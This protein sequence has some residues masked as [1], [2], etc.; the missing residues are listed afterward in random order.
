MY[1]CM[2][3]KVLQKII[4]NWGETQRAPHKINNTALCALT[5]QVITFTRNC[6]RVKIVIIFSLRSI[7]I[8]TVFLKFFQC[9]MCVQVHVH[10]AVHAGYKTVVL[11]ALGMHRSPHLFKVP[12]CFGAINTIHCTCSM[13]HISP[14]SKLPFFSSIIQTLQ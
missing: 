1:T 6:T 10:V 12:L 2:A 3:H 8:N 7:R 9:S 4:H 13:Y 5:Q 14:E 11:C